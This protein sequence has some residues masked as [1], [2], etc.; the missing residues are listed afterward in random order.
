MAA[1]MPDLCP[2]AFPFTRASLESELPERAQEVNRFLA[3]A[4]SRT[5]AVT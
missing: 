5:R 1:Q 4:R 2:I 3:P